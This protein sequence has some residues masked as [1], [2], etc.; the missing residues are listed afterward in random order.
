MLMDVT[1]LY[2]AAAA[3]SAGDDTDT[4]HVAGL[5]DTDSSADPGTGSTKQDVTQTAK[6]EFHAP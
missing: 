6:K 1:A 4:V 2:E 3:A 5:P